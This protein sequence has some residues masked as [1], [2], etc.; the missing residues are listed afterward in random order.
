MPEA[1][2]VT[3]SVT[4]ADRTAGNH[5]DP[6]RICAEIIAGRHT[7]H[8]AEFL[9]AI[10][11]ASLTGASSIRWRI[12]LDALG[13]DY[14]GREVTEDSLTLRA[15]ASAERI[16]GHS[17]KTLSPY[18]SG[19]DCHAIIVAWLIEDEGH[20]PVEAGDIARAV[21]LGKIPDML[22]SY[23]VVHGPKEDG[24]ASGPVSG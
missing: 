10:R 22:D 18:E 9:A 21:T 14:V 6:D 23:E 15:V 4:E 20:P 24:T 17:W 1:R 19:G 11:E 7:G 2:K 13:A 5:L 16:A 12:K 3:P 8:L